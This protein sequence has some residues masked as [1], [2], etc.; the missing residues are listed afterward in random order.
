VVVAE[1]DEIPRGHLAINARNKSSRGKAHP[2]GC[3]PAGSMQFRCNLRPMALETIVG[4]CRIRHACLSAFTRSLHSLANSRSTSQADMVTGAVLTGP[5]SMPRD[6]HKP[7]R[8]ARFIAQSQASV[9]GTRY[10]AHH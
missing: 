4:E 5:K 1:K 3:V 7:P 2:N 8:C 10:G 6:L 9:E